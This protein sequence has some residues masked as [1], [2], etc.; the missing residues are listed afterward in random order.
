MTDNVFEKVRVFP[1]P[2]CVNASKGAAVAHHR[3]IE[4]GSGTHQNTTEQPWVFRHARGGKTC[5]KTCFNDRYWIA[6][7]DR[8][9]LLLSTKHSDCA[10][11]L[12]VLELQWIPYVDELWFVHGLYS[13]DQRAGGI[14][15]I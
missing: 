11:K 7:L 2:G 1:D 3:A 6:A 15:Q 5:S 14:R 8:A 12:F 9:P 4:F 10:V 13:V